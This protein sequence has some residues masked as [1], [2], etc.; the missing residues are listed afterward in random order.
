MENR[1]LSLA[2]TVRHG[3][4]SRLR[5]AL[6]GRTLPDWLATLA[7][8]PVKMF[9]NCL[10]WLLLC[11]LAALALASAMLVLGLCILTCAREKLFGV[12]DR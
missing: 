7:L 5:K 4:A 1:L 12:I 6:Q 10:I 8:V 11:A 2:V 9:M 3:I